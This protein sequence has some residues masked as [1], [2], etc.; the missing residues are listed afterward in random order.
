MRIEVDPVEIPET[1]LF[2]R[3]ASHHRH[4][5]VAAVLAT[6][7]LAACS[8]KNPDSMVGMNVDENLAMMDANQMSHSD[9]VTMNTPESKDSAAASNRSSSGS[10]RRANESAPHTSISA[11]AS[12]NAAD[13]VA[14]IPPT[15]DENANDANEQPNAS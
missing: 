9:V 15:Q 4:K 2:Q 7:L 11:S 1:L 13:A 3:P 12:V 14:T 6:L 8:S 10:V 5:P